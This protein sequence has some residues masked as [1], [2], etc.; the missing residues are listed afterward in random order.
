MGNKSNQVDWIKL[1]FLKR[2]KN[3]RKI[4]KQKARRGENKIK[5]SRAP[6]AIISVCVLASFLPSLL[7]SLIFFIFLFSNFLA[8]F[9]LAAV[10]A[11]RRAGGNKWCRRDG[12]CRGDG[13]C[14]RQKCKYKLKYWYWYRYLRPI[15]PY[16][17]QWRLSGL[18]LQCS[19]VFVCSPASTFQSR[20]Y[21][22]L[23]GGHGRPCAACTVRWRRVG[24][25]EA[26]S[27]GPV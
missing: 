27:W 17:V 24:R 18:H 26:A 9:E 5:K 3:K 22:A 6:A 21:Q 10:A 16:L 11:V 15:V 23:T 12:R 1:T 13:K 7:S 4:R 2:R 25:C 20:Y 8:S 14:C 19:A